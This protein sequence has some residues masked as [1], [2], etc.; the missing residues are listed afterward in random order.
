MALSSDNIDKKQEVKEEV[1]NSINTL[2]HELIPPHRVI[3]Q[4]EKEKLLEKYHIKLKN[5]PRISIK[6]PVIR[7]ITD[8][9]VGDVV[10]IERSSVTAGKTLYYRVIVNA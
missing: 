6:D 4:E 9:K 2:E 3:S 7:T 5:L 1:L 10:E 8:A